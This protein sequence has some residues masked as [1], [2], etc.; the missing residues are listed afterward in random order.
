MT[1]VT[2]TL[3]REG[4]SA[5]ARDVLKQLFVMGPT[6]DGDLASKGGRSD[7]MAAGLVERFDGWNALSRKGFVDAVALGLGD[8]KD[9]RDRERAAQTRSREGQFLLMQRAFA[10]VVRAVGGAVTVP[11]SALEDDG[12]AIMQPGEDGAL[13]FT[14][15]NAAGVDAA[16]A[17]SAALAG[18]IQEGCAFEVEVSE[19]VGDDGAG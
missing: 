7:L 19:K 2:A 1:E 14:Y 13:V 4:L 6:P 3:T 9:A 17:E 16:I 5:A 12:A 10:G 15:I 8:F 18:V 11:V